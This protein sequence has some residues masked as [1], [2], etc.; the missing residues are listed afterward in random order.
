M[1]TPN[2]EWEKRFSE[3]EH[4]KDE[5]V[6]FFPF[7][8]DDYDFSD[9]NCKNFIR[10]EIDSAHKQGYLEGVGKCLEVLPTYVGRAN[11]DTITATFHTGWNKCWV[12]AH[13]AITSLLTNQER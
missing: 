11:E 3:A 4:S 5:Y 2:N 9:E 8:G 10:R 7:G 1:T 13:T 12:D 6:S